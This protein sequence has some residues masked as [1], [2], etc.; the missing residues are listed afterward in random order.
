MKEK[1]IRLDLHRLK[2][3]KNEITQSA[4][5]I[6][7]II[8]KNGEKHDI[9]IPRKTHEDILCLYA[10]VTATH[11]SS[12]EV[13][14]AVS[15]LVDEEA[16][17]GCGSLETYQRGCENNPTQTIVAFCDKY[18]LPL[19]NLLFIS[20]K[21]SFQCER[22]ST[23]ASISSL[24]GRPNDSFVAL[25]TWYIS[26]MFGAETLKSYVSQARNHIDTRGRYD[27]MDRTVFFNHL[28]TE[29]KI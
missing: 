10:L 23:G 6:A 1:K 7:K 21:F 19:G 24:K 11:Y 4:Q 5:F 15:V 18:S 13:E 3:F 20:G 2:G 9:K 12:E 27:I 29:D 16:L 26:L 17:E 28:T 25:M 14:R 8:D 22:T